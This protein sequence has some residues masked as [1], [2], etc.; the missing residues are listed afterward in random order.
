MRFYKVNILGGMVMSRLAA[1]SVSRART[2][3]T[4]FQDS[5]FIEM[6]LFSLS[7]ISLS[8]VTIVKVFFKTIKYNII[9][10][11]VCTAHVVV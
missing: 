11:Y 6:E 4:R 7:H 8:L 5:R 3:H 9:D 2:F 10:T 1:C